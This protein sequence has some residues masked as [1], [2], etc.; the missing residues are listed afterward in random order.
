MVRILKDSAR[1]ER[2]AERERKGERGK[3]WE[4]GREKKEQGGGRERNIWR[5]VKSSLKSLAKY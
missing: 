4:D 5:Y 2:A 1:E 3:Q